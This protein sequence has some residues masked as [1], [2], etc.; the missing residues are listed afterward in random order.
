ASRAK[1]QAS[2][3]AQQL[4]MLQQQVAGAKTEAEEAGKTRDT[5]QQ[6][7]SQA[8]GQAS[9]A[10]QQ[11]AMLQQQIAGAKTEAEEAGRTRD[12]MQQEASQAKGQA[13]DA[14]QQLADLQQKLDARGKQVADLEARSTQAEHDVAES[15]EKLAA[16]KTAFEQIAQQRLALQQQLKSVQ[17]QIDQAKQQEDAATKQASDA[18]AQAAE[19]VRALQATLARQADL[20]MQTDTLQRWISAGSAARD[21][22]LADL[23]TEQRQLTEVRGQ[24]AQATQAAVVPNLRNDFD[25]KAAGALSGA[26]GVTVA[27]HRL[28]VQNDTLFVPG[29][30]AVS[31]A[32]R[33][34]LQQI[35]AML[36]AA[37]ASLPPEAAW[38]L[39]IGGHADK[40]PGRIPNRELSALR[41]TA[42]VKVLEAEG[43]P[44]DH[45]VAAGF[46]DTQP[47]DTGNTQAAYARNRRVEFEIMQRS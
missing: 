45:L 10:A 13:S 40:V 34:M 6:E 3:A 41:A 26:S 29:S 36:K 16:N 42:V 32:G 35:A 19:I 21:K 27:N 22:L 44:P 9:D 18:Q 20:Q 43:L 31:A 12:A 39:L 24:A 11:L 8:K 1:S 2:D 23:Q 15:Q 7:A 14:A 25:S 47:L 30:T 28:I 38:V 33:Q 17:D 4:A 5:M 46:G 37:T